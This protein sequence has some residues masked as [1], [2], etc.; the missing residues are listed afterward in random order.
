MHKT[1][2]TA[3]ASVATLALAGALTI[4]VATIFTT[5]EVGI[6][7]ARQVDPPTVE[8]LINQVKDRRTRMTLIDLLPCESRTK[9]YPLGDPHVINAEDLDGTPSYGVAQFKPDTLY[10]EGMRYHL[11][12]PDLERK[13]IMNLIFDAEI[14]IPIAA[15]MIENRGK[16]RSFWQSQFPACG[17]RF[18]FW[19]Y[20]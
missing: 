4:L 20:Q 10:N 2:G 18:R 14:Q 12:P 19:E 1:I 3:F 15:A 8:D 6:I 16:E 11:L 5:V 13:E 9:D 17:E 7:N